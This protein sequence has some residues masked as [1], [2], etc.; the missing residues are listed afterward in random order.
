MLPRRRQSPSGCSRFPL[1]RLFA[2][3][4]FAAALALTTVTFSG[5]ARLRPG[6]A[7]LAVDH[8]RCD[9]AENPLGIDSVAPR[10]SWQLAS[11]AR[12]ARQT[13]A[14][15]LVASSE[16]ELAREAGDLWDSGVIRG[17]AQLGVAYHGKPLRSSQRVFWKVRVWDRAG[18]PS[19][20]S[21]PA[22]WTMGVVRKMDWHAQ[23]IT[24]AVPP[25]PNGS[26]L[27]RREFAVRPGLRRALVHVTGV[28]AYELA[29][30]GERVSDELLS[31][32][33]TAYAKT[34]LYDTHDITA[35]LHPG[36][37][38]AA[39]TLGGGMY[40][41]QRAAGRFAKFTNTYAPSYA[42]AQL[43]LEYADGSVD[44]VCTDRN[45]RTYAS[46]ITYSNIYGGET[47]VAP[48]VQAGWDRAG[49]NDFDWPA[50]VVSATGPGGRLRGES[51]AA[52]P[53]RAHE[54]LKPVAMRDVK[55]PPDAKFV[56]RG[57][58]D[59][60][61]I[62]LQEFREVQ[63]G[64]TVYDLGQNA[65]LIPRLRV[66]GPAG[67]TVAITP[68][69]LVKPDGSIDRDSVGGARGTYA[70]TYTLA[71]TPGGEEWFPEFSYQGC[72]YLQVRR[73]PGADGQLPVI[74]ALEGVVVNAAS[75]PAGDFA[76][77]DELFNRIRT[78]VRWAQRSN[79]MSILT[80]C[81]HRE[82]LGWLE[83]YHLNGA[84]LRYE[85]DLGKLDLKT[86]AD[87]AEA[88]TPEGLVPNIAPEY[89]V[90]KD[91]F[92]DSPEWG[93]TVVLAAWQHYVWTGDVSLLAARYTTMQRYVAYLGTTA[94]GHIVDHGLGDW[95]DLGPGKLGAS[96]NTPVAV[97]ATAMYYDDLQKLAAIADV[98]GHTD[99]AAGYRA[100]AALVRD[101]FDEK[102][103]HHET[104]SYATGS[105]CANSVALVT[106]LVPEG[107]R[108]RVLE[109]VVTDVRAKG[110][111]A[112]D[113]GYRYLLR[114]L[115][116]GERSDVIYELNHQTDKP[117]YGYQLAQGATSLGESWDAGRGKSQDHFM[118]GQITEWFYGDLAGLTP[119]PAAPGWG[120]A[121]I[122]PQP[123]A[124]IDWARASVATPHGK[125]AVSWKRAAGR[126]T[127]EI[128]VPAGGSATVVLP[129]SDFRQVTEGDVAATRATGVKY[130]RST[131]GTAEFAVGAGKYA[132][133]CPV[134]AMPAPSVS[135]TAAMAL[136]R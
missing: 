47:Y 38:A 51:H 82:R 109:A 90:F 15:V 84:A 85:Y 86:F 111:T 40:S 55:G 53:V 62:A 70:W 1:F 79:I 46:P 21:A 77:S 98:L 73:F 27:L 16:A 94:K 74:D 33:W 57:Q 5:C 106:G 124:G 92:R 136:G 129:A 114:A 128:E 108:A 13:A 43:R 91:A 112:G 60:R 96:Q 89:T 7:D 61:A 131:R 118:L 48:L 37:N 104:G 30:N 32:G 127:L 4:V 93:A 44:Q 58:E 88:Q 26:L 11:D 36:A 122:R 20:W 29:L 126:F 119:D 25:G 42:I 59:R 49:F 6:S 10:L 45:W 52:P 113:V 17:E 34:V 125:Y 12:G 121:I 14:Q 99:D 39:L 3:P 9:L 8:L 83:Q 95:F 41:V 75:E 56:Y 35:L 71:G 110:L 18:L 54:T 103:Y 123:V 66:H 22:E 63:A 76:C 115:A 132:F 105:Q 100:E 134:P 133:A 101:A 64:V 68:A 23:W 28:G 69:E 87:M 19:A 50:A 120:R 72:R 116:D 107:I 135:S 65:S 31:P 80:D 67:S 81:P 24:A 2:F 117:G 97:T 130:M 102:F 78:L